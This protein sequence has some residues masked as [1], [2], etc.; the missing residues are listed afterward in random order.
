MRPEVIDLVKKGPLPSARGGVELIKEWQEML[1]RITPPVFDKEAEALTELFPANDDDCFGLA[2]SL[3]HL[4][5]TSPDW[6]LQ[7][8]LQNSDN[9]WIAR[10]QQR[11]R[12]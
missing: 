1:E 9:P 3:I 5:E 11:A 7:R 12:K 2:W 4:I 10:L 8:C 6:P